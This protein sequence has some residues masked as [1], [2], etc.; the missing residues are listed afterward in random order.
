MAYNQRSGSRNFAPRQNFSNNSQPKKKHSGCKFYEN[1][2]KPFIAG[3]N[4]STR[5]GMRKFIASPYEGKTSSTKRTESK[6]GKHW[7]NWRVKI[8][9]SDG[10]QIWHSCLYDVQ[11]RRVFINDLHLMMSPKSPNGGYIGKIS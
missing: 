6:S 3:W 7:E 8:T 1:S 2:G 9:L 10:Q 11:N 4:Y 5:N